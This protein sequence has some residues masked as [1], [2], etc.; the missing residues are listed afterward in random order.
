MQGVGL[1]GQVRS[2]RGRENAWRP[3]Q[4]WISSVLSE[5][6]T[7]APPPLLLNPA[8]DEGNETHHSDDVRLSEFQRNVELLQGQ[9]GERQRDK[10]L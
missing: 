4:P 10:D 9:A 1:C 7:R 3:A 6:A 8:S 5:G 2:R